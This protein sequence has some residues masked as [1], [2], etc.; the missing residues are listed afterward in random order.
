METLCMS[1]AN[2][3]ILPIYTSKFVPLWIATRC[4]EFFLFRADGEEC[5][6]D[7]LANLLRMMKPKMLK[8]DA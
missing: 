3:L 4:F 5:L 7:L 1:I 2:D 8:M 6:F